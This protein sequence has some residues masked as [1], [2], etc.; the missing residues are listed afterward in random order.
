MLRAAPWDCG[1]PT[2]TDRPEETIGDVT[3]STS[4]FETHEPAT[5]GAVPTATGSRDARKPE[6]PGTA[7][8][9]ALTQ[10]TQPSSFPR[11]T[12]RPPSA[13]AADVVSGPGVG[14][15]DNSGRGT[16]PSPNSPCS[17]ISDRLGQEHTFPQ[18]LTGGALLP[19]DA[20]DQSGLAHNR[21][22][23]HYLLK[24]QESP[25]GHRG[26]THGPRRSHNLRR[27]VGLNRPGISGD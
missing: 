25:G 3:R 1:A 26:A 13:A 24:A 15:S 16:T 4:K 14:P 11:D 22:R 10:R 6:R 12:P 9:V 7:T 8:P 27:R 2:D 23:C 5:F 20:P 18:P 17:G 21:D 19:C